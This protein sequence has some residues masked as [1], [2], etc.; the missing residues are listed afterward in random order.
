[1]WEGFS[2]CATFNRFFVVPFFCCCWSTIPPIFPFSHCLLWSI[3]RSL[4]CFFRLFSYRS[5]QIKSG[6]LDLLSEQRWTYLARANGFVAMRTTTV[7][8]YVFE[9]ASQCELD[10]IYRFTLS[11][12]D[13]AFHAT[14]I[15]EMAVV[16]LAFFSSFSSQTFQSGKILWQSTLRCWWWCWWCCCYYIVLKVPAHASAHFGR[17]W[18]KNFYFLEE[19][20][21]SVA[22]KWWWCLL[23]GGVAHTEHSLIL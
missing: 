21:G 11:A 5:F 14:S 18:M 2:G 9:C 15:Y 8:T 17:S 13:S 16:V 7:M 12:N 1:M 22:V 6:I 19:S 4:L 23:V 10:L 20:F 3:A